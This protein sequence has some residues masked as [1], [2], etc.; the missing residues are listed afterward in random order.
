MSL[1]RIFSI[2]ITP[3]NNLT[4]SPRLNQKGALT[5]SRKLRAHN[6]A[7][8][9]LFGTPSDFATGFAVDIKCTTCKGL[10]EELAQRKR[11]SEK[12]GKESD[13]NCKL[14]STC[15]AIGGV[16]LLPAGPGVT[17]HGEDSSWIKPEFG[18]EVVCVDC[19]ENFQF[20]T[21]CGGGGQW[22]TGR[23]RPKP[24]FELGRKTCNL[25][26][27]RL[28]DPSKFRFVVYRLPVHNEG[29]EPVTKLEGFI[30][31]K[32]TMSAIPY[33]HL[34]MEEAI[35]RMAEDVSEFWDVAS[36]T[37]IADAQTMKA[38]SYAS[39]WEDLIATKNLLKEQMKLMIRGQFL[40]SFD[41]S[42]YSHRRFR[43]FLT[44]GFCPID[45]SKAETSSISTK[46]PMD[47]LRGHRIVACIAHIWDIEGRHIM[48]RYSCTLGQFG[49]HPNSILP[50][51]N[52]AAGE[53]ILANKAETAHV[54][55]ADFVW[56]LGVWGRGVER[57]RKSILPGMI[58][59][60]TQLI[61]DY[62]AVRGIEEKAVRERLNDFLMEREELA[63]RDIVVMEF[64]VLMAFLKWESSAALVA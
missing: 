30:H 28:G 19:F 17:G 63:K 3:T 56:G 14:C 62:C 41:P 60:G 47:P 5:P 20:C 27:L 23:W 40:P 55:R 35:E 52:F 11:K 51:L 34:P 61:E 64:Q 43:R 29:S 50:K 37:T 36:V 2:L 32:E 7:R 13:V 21:K 57:S 22:R 42:E 12:A 1:Y 38:L 8:L 16:R 6:L 4:T 45:K 33:V 44:L 24:M 39:N 15:I 26:H 49:F 9:F 25:P 31:N 18:I 48:A 59:R 53:R 54:P 46:P 58:A 10:A